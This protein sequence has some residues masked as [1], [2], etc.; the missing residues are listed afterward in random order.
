M[1]RREDKDNWVLITQ[2]DHSRLAGEIMEYWGNERFSGPE[3]REEVLF[4]VREHDSG[5]KEWDA[6][7]KVDPESGYPANFAEMD[8]KDQSEIW[9]RC[10]MANAQEHPYASSLTALHFAKFNQHNIDKYPLDKYSLLLKKEIRQFVADKLG[11]E[12][13]D[14]PQ[15]EIQA[16]VKVNLKLLQIGDIVS[17]TLCHGWRSIEI[18]DVPLDYTGNSIILKMEAPDGLNYT[19]TPYPFSKPQL[20]FSIACR[21]LG[22]KVF[23]DDK[24]YRDMLSRAVQEKLEFKISKL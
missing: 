16:D 9:K 20:N 12:F 14:S 5:W 6:F 15:A 19:V 1:I 23:S 13:T 3:P 10:F 18:A 7:P 17:L 11:I 21:R 4:A 24:E 8:T 2:D 22:S